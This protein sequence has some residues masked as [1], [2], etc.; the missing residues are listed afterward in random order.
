MVDLEVRL[1]SREQRA[2]ASPR[3]KPMAEVS[4][5]IE[6]GGVREIVV[7]V[8]AAK[9]LLASPP[10]LPCEESTAF[11]L[12]HDIEYK[13]CKGALI[14]MLSRRDHSVREIE[15]KLYSYGYRSEEIEKTVTFGVDHGF[16]DDVRFATTF[17][18]TRKLRGWGRRRIELELKKAGV[19]AE[20]VLGYP[21]DY[22]SSEED[23]DRAVSMLSRK[24][25]PETRAKEKFIRF[26]VSRGFDYDV[27]RH[28]AEY[29][30]EQSC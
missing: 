6:D 16:L 9:L 4:C 21:D 15:E 18:S 7:P 20:D 25:I 2:S 3:R 11:D 5:F 10:G 8:R 29:V 1:P 22:F 28:A 26:L 27:S 24:S 23:Y 19:S 12:I 30:L 17:I 14:D 13:A